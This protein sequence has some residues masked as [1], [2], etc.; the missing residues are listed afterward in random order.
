MSVG[1]P[2]SISIVNYAPGS[3]ETALRGLWHH[4]DGRELL[5]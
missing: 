1:L 4:F 5:F 3:R 2:Q